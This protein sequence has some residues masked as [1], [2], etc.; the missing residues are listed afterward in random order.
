MNISYQ[1]IGTIHTPFEGIEQVPI[2][3]TGADG[4]GGTVEVLPEFAAGLQDLDGF[5]HIILLYHFHRVTQVKLTVVPFLDVEPRGVFATR[6]PSR[7]NPIGLSIV[8]LLSIEGNVLQIE[9]VDIVDGTPLLDIKPYVPA[10]DYNEVERTG[11]L[12][13]AGEAV[14]EKRS[15]DRF[16]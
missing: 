10:F 2:Q 8:R 1:P 12:E 9:N 7:P 14:K 6:A 15:D 5:S 3:P 11:W 13:T 4:I 16:R